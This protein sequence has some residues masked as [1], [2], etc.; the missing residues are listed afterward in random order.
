[1]THTHSY[2][3]T[4]SYRASKTMPRGQPSYTQAQ[5]DCAAA[6]GEPRKETSFDRDHPKWLAHQETWHSLL[7]PGETLPACR[8]NSCNRT[9]EPASGQNRSDAW[10]MAW[11]RQSSIMATVSKEALAMTSFGHTVKLRVS[12]EWVNKHAPDIV[13]VHAAAPCT[14]PTGI[15]GPGVKRSI[16]ATFRGADG[17]IIEE[18]DEVCPRIANV[19]TQLTQARHYCT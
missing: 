17:E 3:H 13:E 9:R 2:A 7:S 19:R 10:K 5:R 4:H 11:R 1:M 6:A 15:N 14:T 8:C 12:K 18:F 16:S